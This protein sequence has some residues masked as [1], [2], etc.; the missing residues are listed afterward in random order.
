MRAALL[1][2]ITLALNGQTRDFA[3]EAAPKR[4]A[5]VIGNNA[6]TKQPLANAVNDAGDLAKA[7]QK[8]GFD[9]RLLLDADLRTMDVAA[10]EFAQGLRPGDV[11]LFYFSGHG[12]SLEGENFLLPVSFAAEMEADVRYQALSASRVRDLIRGQ[13][14]R[15]SILI[16]DACRSNPFRG[17]RATGGGGLSG[18]S[19]AGAFIAFAADEGKTA[20]DNPKDRNGLFTKHLLEEIEKPGV[21][22]EQLFTRVRTRVYQESQGKQIPFSY[23]GLIGE[24]VF[25]DLPPPPPTPPPPA[26][27][28]ELPKPEAPKAEPPKAE[29]PKAEPP[30]AEPPKVEAP[31][32]ETPK[33]LSAKPGEKRLNRADGLT[34]VYVPPGQATIGCVPA[35]ECEADDLPGRIVETRS[36]FWMG[37]TEVTRDAFQRVMG[38]VPPLRLEPHKAMALIMQG[39]LPVAD[40]SANQAREYCQKVGLRLP[41]EFEWEFAARAGQAGNQPTPLEQFA[42]FATQEARSVEQLIRA[43]IYPRAV[44][45]KQTNALGL[46]DMLGNVGEFALGAENQAQ[47]YIRGGSFVQGADKVRFSRRYALPD[48]A[49]PYMNFGFRCA[50]PNLN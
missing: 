36:G 20:D 4:K 38:K 17:T 41:T 45:Q 9:T 13:N 5:L 22:L 47:I 50:G 37:E 2:A 46:Y 42:W 29:P 11:A 26:P 24:F 8:V 7:L 28:T 35:S 39:R 23:S 30:K 32:L 27:K 48:P 25:K 43:G 31:K 18:M 12:M 1:F 14:V 49:V 15:L 34:Y 44:A 40:I 6:Y 21:G 10:R 33:V 3:I 19:G 16:F